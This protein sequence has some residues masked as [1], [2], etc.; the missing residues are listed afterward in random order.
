MKINSVTRPIA[1]RLP[2]LRAEIA[3]FS[4]QDQDNTVR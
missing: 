4:L 3:L 2:G 1:S